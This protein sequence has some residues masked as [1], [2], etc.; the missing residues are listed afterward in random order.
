MWR[1]RDGGQTWKTLTDFEPTLS[2]GAIML[3]PSNPDVIYFGTGE[4][5]GCQITLFLGF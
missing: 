5:N 2:G 4:G 3:D 1:T